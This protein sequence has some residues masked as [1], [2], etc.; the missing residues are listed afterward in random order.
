MVIKIS[1][2]G[3]INAI[4]L[5]IKINQPELVNTKLATGQQNFTEKFT[6]LHK[7][8]VGYFWQQV[9]KISRKKNSQIHKKIG[10]RGYFFDSHCIH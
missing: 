7:N 8:C 3:K 1:T 2:S 9:S 5:N 10:G 4:L 6:N